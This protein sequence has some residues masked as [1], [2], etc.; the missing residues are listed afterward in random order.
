LLSLT[1]SL[2]GGPV[3]PFLACMT[4]TR[5]KSLTLTIRENLAAAQTG[6]DTAR[7]CALEQA[8]AAA[9]QMI[10]AGVSIPAEFAG[11]L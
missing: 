7:K 3:R 2:K 10:R 5:I 9:A 8:A 1:I 6:T 11:R 4:K